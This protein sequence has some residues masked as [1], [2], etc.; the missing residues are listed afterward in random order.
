[1]VTVFNNI[2]IDWLKSSVYYSLS[3]ESV[4]TPDDL[5]K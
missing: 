2:I 4:V 1:M 3:I 5:Q